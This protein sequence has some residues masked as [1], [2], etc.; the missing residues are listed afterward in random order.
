[1]R[2][3]FLLMNITLD[4]Y[5][6][7]PNHDISWANNNNEAFPSDPDNLVDTL[8]FG[9]TTYEGMVSFWPTDMA[10]QMMPDVA[11]FMNDTPKVVVSHNDFDPGWENVRV[12]SGDVIEE[13]KKLKAGPG[14]TI[15]MFGSNTLC[16]SLMAHGLVDEFQILVNPVAIG[17]GTPLFL[18]LQDRTK[19]TLTQS[20]Q[21]ANGTMM[22]TYVPAT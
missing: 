12:I 22:M 9:H 19:L 1:M 6:E 7:G 4:G 20:R 5:F 13:I 8:L 15:G 18:G 16:V 2:K 3:I 17:T 21:F 14:K 10:K 11:R